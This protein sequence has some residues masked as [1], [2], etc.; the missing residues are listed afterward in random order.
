MPR[1]M[2]NDCH[3]INVVY[4][5]TLDKWVWVDPTFDAYVVDENG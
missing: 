3:V 2:V 1:K 5:A 4:S